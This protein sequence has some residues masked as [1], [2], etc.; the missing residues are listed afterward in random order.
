MNTSKLT[1]T[2]NG[3]TKS[4]AAWARI[5]GKPYAVLVS[6]KKAGWDDADIIERPARRYKK[7]KSGA[8]KYKHPRL[9]N[10]LRV[11]TEGEALSGCTPDQR[12]LL[13]EFKH[14][15]DNGR[16]FYEPGVA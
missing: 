16:W 13:N 1:I 7:N 12:A 5:T 2:Y 4:V 10:G 6:R 14:A 15:A 9:K 11:A 3:L 8:T